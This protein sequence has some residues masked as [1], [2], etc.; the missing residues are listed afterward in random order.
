MCADA[1][2]WDGL[3]EDGSCELVFTAFDPV[4]WGQEQEASAAA[5]STELSL[6]VGGTYRTWPTFVMEASAGGGV[7]VEDV[8]AGARVE[9]ERAFLGGE[10]VIVDCAAGRAWVDGEAADTDVTLDSDFFWLEP[11]SHEL[12]F[13]G[14]ADFTANFTERWL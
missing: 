2:T 8:G 9:V 7:V 1:G 4:A 6:L 11:G 12:S 13:T 14:C 3:F 5:G 10:E